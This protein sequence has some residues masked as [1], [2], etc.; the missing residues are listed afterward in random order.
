MDSSSGTS[1]KIQFQIVNDE[2]NQNIFFKRDG[3]RFG[4]E[5]TLK[6]KTETKYRCTVT[7]KPSI[8]LQSVSAQDALVNLIDLTKQNGSSTYEFEWPT[9]FP[10]NKRSK[11]TDIPIVLRFQDGLTLTI[12]LQVKFY[13]ADN[14]QHLN[15]G[16]QMHFIDYDCRIKPERSSIVIEKTQ[17]Y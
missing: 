14:F 16:Q 7:I 9:T 8:P 15:W 10:A 6:L 5:F 2:E 11:R 13:D 3:Q 1:L 12:P 17:F 4:Q